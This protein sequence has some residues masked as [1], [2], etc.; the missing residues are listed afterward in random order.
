M[1]QE[2]YIIHKMKPQTEYKIEDYEEKI[3]KKPAL[4]TQLLWLRN[5]AKKAPPWTKLN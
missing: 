3:N 1:L 5:P 2:N 4:V